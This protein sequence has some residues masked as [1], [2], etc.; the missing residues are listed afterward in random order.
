[1]RTNKKLMRITRR[2]KRNA[3]K[4]HKTYKRKFLKSKRS[5]K[6]QMKKMMGG[7]VTGNV[8]LIIDPQN[9]FTDEL[10]GQNLYNSSGGLPVPGAKND[11]DKLSR[12]LKKFPNKFDEIH[13]SLDS[14]TKRH[15][16]HIG[17]WKS[18]SELSDEDKNNHYT[19]PNPYDVF[20]V[21]EK[22]ATQ[23]NI[24]IDKDY[25]KKVKTNYP[26]LQVWAYNYILA[27]QNL[28]KIDPTKPEP[29]LWAEHC[30]IGKFENDTENGWKIYKPLQEVLNTLKD[31]VFYHE[32]GTNDLVEMYSIF[33]AEIPYE[34]L[35]NNSEINT[36]LNTPAFQETKKYI[37]TELYSG[38]YKNI[39][40]IEEIENSNPLVNFE[41][42]KHT[43]RNYNT[44]FNTVLFQK[45]RGVNN[46]NKIYVC[47]EAKTH[48]VKTS[49]E[50]MVKHCDEFGFNKSNISLLED[51]TSP[52]PFEIFLQA[53]KTAYDKLKK[54]GVN[55]ITSD[56]L[57]LPVEKQSE[58]TNRLI[59][60]LKKDF[61]QT[62]STKYLVEWEKSL[63][64]IK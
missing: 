49:L 16:G 1:M 59:K 6:R 32:K 23:Q 30:I 39:K 18:E 55:I 54:E 41:T 61:R 21:D 48:C 5:T 29:C 64:N 63:H 33:S 56:S 60:P 44:N 47:G 20:Y 8:L 25:T 57:L 22:D 50:D 31:K 40:K 15:I 3:L 46:S 35:L 27:M 37:E 4:K 53:A 24:Y 9:D 26:E 43:Y 28:R 13:V 52:I 62:I 51:M 34:D 42:P 14:H 45:L 19:V 10:D 38:L 58:S 12:F 17:F 2:N 11:L 7:G 36:N